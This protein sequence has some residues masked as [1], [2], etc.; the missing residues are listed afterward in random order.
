[1]EKP[2]WVEK[3]SVTKDNMGLP[4]YRP[5]KFRDGEPVY[6]IVGKLEKRYG[7]NITF[8]VFN[9]TYPDDWGVYVNGTKLM[10][11]SRYRNKNANTVYDMDS[12]DFIHHIESKTDT[13]I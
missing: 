13:P 8:R 7:F 6:K 9:S 12:D 1:M 5:P 3:N 11:I 10:E 2:S 4:E